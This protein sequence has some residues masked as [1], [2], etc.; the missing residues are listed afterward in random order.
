VKS[1][2]EDDDGEDLIAAEF[3]EKVLKIED[4]NFKVECAD[5]IKR[6]LRQGFKRMNGKLASTYRKNLTECEL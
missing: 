3:M 1:D 5:E 2:S 6:M 4:K